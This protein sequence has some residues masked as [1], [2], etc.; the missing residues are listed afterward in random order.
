[1]CFHEDSI[2]C[3]CEKENKKISEKFQ[4]LHF[5]WSFSNS[6]MAM[7]GLVTWFGPKRPF[8]KRCPSWIRGSNQKPLFLIFGFFCASLSF[9][10]EPE[11]TLIECNC[12]ASVLLATRFYSVLMILLGSAG[13]SIVPPSPPSRMVDHVCR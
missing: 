13:F 10:N 1:M 4:I 2:T 6:I 9:S 11:C 8:E 7:K 3:S 5:Y 12:Y